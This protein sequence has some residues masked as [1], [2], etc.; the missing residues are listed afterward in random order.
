[1]NQLVFEILL[2]GVRDQGRIK[3]RT[4]TLQVV[5]ELPSEFLTVLEALFLVATQSAHNDFIEVRVANTAFDRRRR[6]NVTRAGLDHPNQL[7]VVFSREKLSA[8]QHFPEHDRQSELIGSV[9]EILEPHRLFGREVRR[10][11]LDGS[12]L[13]LLFVHFRLHDAEVDDLHLAIISNQDVL[14]RNVAMD[15]R[16]FLA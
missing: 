12:H 7:H 1:M 15:D 16:E 5:S 6:L 2:H 4:I 9:I 13:G 11:A 3:V 10:L 8:N 14:R